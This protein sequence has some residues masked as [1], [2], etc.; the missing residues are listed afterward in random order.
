V[1]R[2]DSPRELGEWVAITGRPERLEPVR[3]R[4]LEVLADGRDPGIGLTER[5]GTLHF[6]HHWVIAVATAGAR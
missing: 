3:A 4:M 1:D 6:V 5:D 2:W